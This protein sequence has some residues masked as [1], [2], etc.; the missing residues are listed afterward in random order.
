MPNKS[1]ERTADAARNVRV[2]SFSGLGEFL[3][4]ERSPA[5]QLPAVSPLLR[6]G[7]AQKINPSPISSSGQEN[8]LY[9]RSKKASLSTVPSRRSSTLSPTLPT[10]PNGKALPRSPNG[11]PRVRL[12]WAQPN[13]PYLGSGDAK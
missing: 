8:I 6:K 7:A 4:R 9:L 11:P 13:A 2:V 12:V 3:V 5:A 10:T 1:L